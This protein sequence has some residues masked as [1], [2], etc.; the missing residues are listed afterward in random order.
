MDVTLMNVS[1]CEINYNW[2]PI[3]ESWQEHLLNLWGFVV[4]L[5]GLNDWA[6]CSSC[7][8]VWLWSP[9]MS[10]NVFLASCGQVSSPCGVR[11]TVGDFSEFGVL[12]VETETRTNCLITRHV[13]CVTWVCTFHIWGFWF[14]VHSAE[15]EG[16]IWCYICVFGTFAPCCVS[17]ALVVI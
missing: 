11:S 1:G 8:S 13:L 3:Y 14:Q 6:C 9:L 7:Q 2:S 12:N 5:N 4:W 16:V 17:A 15:P 10:R